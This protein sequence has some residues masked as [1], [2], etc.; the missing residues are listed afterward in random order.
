MIQ[1][2]KGS[3]MQQYGLGQSRHREA[4]D[5]YVFCPVS[6]WKLITCCVWVQVCILT[7]WLGAWKMWALIPSYCLKYSE[8]LAVGSQWNK[9]VDLGSERRAAY[10]RRQSR[11]LWAKLCLRS[12]VLETEVDGEHSYFSLLTGFTAC[13]HLKVGMDSLSE[14]ARQGIG[15]LSYCLFIH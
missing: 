7:L 11:V 12:A 13:H 14:R 4:G 15:H 1:I 5:I 3:L 6:L 9:H 8:E 2:Q 10:A